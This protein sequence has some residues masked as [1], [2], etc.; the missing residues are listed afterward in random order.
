[1][2]DQRNGLK[3]TKIN[4]EF[5]FSSVVSLCLR[6]RIKTLTLPFSS[7]IQTH[8]KKT[9]CNIQIYWQSSGMRFITLTHTCTGESFFFPQWAWFCLSADLLLLFWFIASSSAVSVSFLSCFVVFSL[10]L[11]LRQYST[12]CLD[13]FSGFARA[14]TICELWNHL[15][16]KIW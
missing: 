10:L 7:W 11:I 6:V 16:C 3:Q 8:K 15:R 4:W 12:L 9:C 13:G 5:F 14:R 2:N 1:M